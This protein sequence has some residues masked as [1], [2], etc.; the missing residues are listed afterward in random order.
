MK[1]GTDLPYVNTG[2][3]V[4]KSKQAINDLS[5][6]ESFENVFLSD[7]IYKLPDGHTQKV[8]DIILDQIGKSKNIQLLEE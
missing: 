6:I 3:S 1:D 2:V 4:D 8:G 5:E 7:I